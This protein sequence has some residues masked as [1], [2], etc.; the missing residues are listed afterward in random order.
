ML[1]PIQKHI[2]EEWNNWEKYPE[3]YFIS[4]EALV[5]SVMVHFQILE[6]IN[7]ID[8]NDEYQK[9]WISMFK[10]QGSAIVDVEDKMTKQIAREVLDKARDNI[11]KYSL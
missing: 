10:T 3:M 5:A 4:K 1:T 8:M 7:V 6:V 9:I 11:K 2:E